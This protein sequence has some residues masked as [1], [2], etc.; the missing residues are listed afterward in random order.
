MIR[1]LYS[2]IGGMN[3]FQTK[4]D[5]IGNNISNVNTFGFKKG[6]VTFNDLVSQQLAGASSPQEGERGGTNPRQVGLGGSTASIDNI[7]T[8]GSLQNTG[9]DLDMAI[10]GDGFFQVGD[11][12]QDYYTRAGNFYLDENGMLVNSEG[13]RVQGF[14]VDGD[15]AV[16]EAAG[17]G[18]LFIPAGEQVNPEA[19]TEVNMRG[20]LNSSA[21]V[22]EERTLR[23]F[24]TDPLGGEQELRI[25][26]TKDAENEWSHQ[27][28]FLDGD[29]DWTD[30][31]S[32]ASAPIDFDA[33]DDSS[34]GRLPDDF[35]VSIDDPG[36]LG[37]QWGDAGPIALNMGSVTQFNS[38]S[39]VEVSSRNGSSDGTLES[40]NVSETGEINGV[41]SNG[42]VRLLGQ[43]ALVN[44]NNPSGLSKTGSNL[45]E[46]SNNSG[47][48]QIGFPGV[49]GRGNLTGSTL[50][51]SNVDL[52]E[53][54][55]EMIVSQRGF[56]AN[57]RM[58][59]TSDEILQ[60][61]INLKR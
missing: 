15:G 54:F 19:T 18:D 17:V 44:F 37:D 25:Q 39:T 28:Q 33:D 9:R 38:P 48:P 57:T 4:L 27:T 61:L 35:N 10:S 5:V 41:F 29:G 1:S 43:I 21:E 7:Q 3:N 60:E 46:V 36:G 23:F 2:G 32:T 6:R 24:A 31:A 34:L 53:E 50:E 22:G 55:A 20:N 8:Q 12:E 11:G 58:I 51:M 13:L 30:I 26:L 56:Q 52:A 40:Y 14:G 16:D 45:Y 59:T 47:E 42:E 49:G